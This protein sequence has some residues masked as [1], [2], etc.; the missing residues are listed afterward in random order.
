MTLAPHNKISGGKLL[1]SKTQPSANRAAAV[2]RMAAVTL[3]RSD[4]ALAAFYRSMCLKLDKGK[5]ITATARKLAILFYRMLSEK[6]EYREV[7]AMEY[8]LAQRRRILRSFKRR[9]E[10]MGFQLVDVTTGEL[11]TGAVS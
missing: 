11:L 5:A 1:S 10:S 7:S 2:F 9:A 8:D 6:L 4:N 3:G